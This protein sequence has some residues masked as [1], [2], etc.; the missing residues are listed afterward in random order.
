ML[1]LSRRL[2]ERTQITLPD[3]RVG[4]ITVVDIDRNKVRLGFDLPAD[5]NIAREELLAPATTIPIRKER[6]D[7][8]SNEESQAEV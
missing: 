3:G 2:N 6:S 7:A 8:A 4:W 5:V 1:V